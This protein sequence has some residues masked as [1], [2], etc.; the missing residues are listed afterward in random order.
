MMP[1]WRCRTGH[2]RTDTTCSSILGRHGLPARLICFIEHG[3]RLLASFVGFLAIL[4]AVVTW[5]CERRTW[6]KIAAFGA[7]ALV[8]FQGI[9]GGAR[10]LLEDRQIAQVHGIVGPTFF[11]YAIFFTAVTSAWWQQANDAIRDVSRGLTI[12]AWI[13]SAL[14]LLQLVCGS[15][16]RHVS[17]LTS[18]AAF[19]WAIHTHVTLAV[20]LMAIAPILSWAGLRANGSRHL[21]SVPSIALTCLILLQIGLGCHNVVFEV[22][23]SGRYRRVRA[24]FWHHLGSGRYPRFDAVNGTR[25]QRRSNTGRQHV[26]G[27][28]VIAVCSCPN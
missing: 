11:A 9:L 6:V 3:H 19:G 18:R 8:V 5:H 17:G 2:L 10:V 13:V 14:A 1:A 21:F 4:M 22:W 7:L 23:S 26:D 27:S 20:V 24:S 15:Q 12:F 16:L 25:G 28:A